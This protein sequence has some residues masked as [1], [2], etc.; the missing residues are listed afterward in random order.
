[1]SGPP[2][3]ILGLFPGLRQGQ[4]G[5]I[6]VSGRVAQQVLGTLGSDPPPDWPPG[7]VHLLTY[8]E[9]FP[10]PDGTGPPTRRVRTQAGAWLAARRLPGPAHLVLVWHVGLARL[11]PA[12]RQPPAVVVVYLHGVEAWRPLGRGVARQLRSRRQPTLILANSAHTWGRACAAN[13]WLADLDHRVVALGVGHPIRGALPPPEHPASLLM[14]GRLAQ[15]EDY[16]GHREVIAC[17]PDVLAEHPGARLWIAGEGDLRASLQAQA[18][19]LDLAAH[20]SFFGQVR[21]ADKEALLR[22]CRA[23]GLPSRGEGFGLVYA[24]AMRLGRP[25]LVSTADAGREV[26]A[27]PLAGLAADPADRPGLARAIGRLLADGPAWAAW[28]AAARARYVSHFTEEHYRARLRTA[29][30]EAGGP[31]RARP[32]AGGR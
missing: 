19:A 9:A 15:D 31:P 17:W 7:R 5:G 21:E 14:L 6:Q 20:V 12:L 27:P 22:R 2:A 3:E 24:E 28:S 30:A 4:A 11:L 8:G 18:S 26:V 16:K 23:F 1:M 10:A 29:L 25:C 13:P 32:G